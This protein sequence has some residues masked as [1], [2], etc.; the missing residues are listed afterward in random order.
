MIRPYVP[1]V[2]VLLGSLKLVWLSVL[3]NSPRNCS[4][5]LSVTGKYFE[6][7]QP[8]SSSRGSYDEAAARRLW[9]VSERLTGISS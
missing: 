5:T 2:K 3:K 6:R 1:A 8:T 4:F 9:E 7:K